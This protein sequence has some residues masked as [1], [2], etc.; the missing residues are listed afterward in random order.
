MKSLLLFDLD[1]TLTL[2]RGKVTEKMKEML[3]NIDKTKYDLGVV[4]GSDLCKI[5]D[6]LED[7]LSNFT[8]WFTENGL[9]SYKDGHLYKSTNIVSFLGEGGYQSVI[10][11][12]LLC[13]SRINLPVKRGVFL[14]LRTGLLNIC[15]VGR[16]CTQSEREEFE[17][18]DNEFK[19]RQSIVNYLSNRFKTLRFSIG[20]QISI[21][22]FPEGWDKRYCLQFIE[23]IYDEI[24]F[25]GDKIIPGGND[26]EI[27]N[28]KR[29][30]PFP[31][32]NWEDTYNLLNNLN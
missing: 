7:S 1:N 23:G 2:S 14:E 19:I 17:K 30:K 20:G 29:V 22:A 13:L 11:E 18:Y 15:P 3:N 24:R 5:R 16:S 21:D 9:V 12:C 8:W 28:D 6:Q 31:V 32:N 26:Y 4:S 10:N 25:Y 27:G